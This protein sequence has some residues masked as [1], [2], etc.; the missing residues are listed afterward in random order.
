[1]DDCVDISGIIRFKAPDDKMFIFF[2]KAEFSEYRF[3]ILFPPN[4]NPGFNRDS[5][6]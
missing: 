5:L 2:L 1:M 6:L 4:K 3:A